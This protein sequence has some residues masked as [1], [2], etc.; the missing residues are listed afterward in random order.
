M[1]AFVCKDAS[2]GDCKGSMRMSG[3]GLY[4][5]FHLN[6]RAQELGK[7]TVNDD[8]VLSDG[9]ILV[10]GNDDYNRRHPK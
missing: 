4:C 10:Q 2:S 9:S 8:S 3:R 7:F 1:I 6:Q 5:T